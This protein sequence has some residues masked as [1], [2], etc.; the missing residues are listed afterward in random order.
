MPA[1]RVL[2]PLEIAPVAFAAEGEVREL[3]GRTMG[4]SWSVKLV[5]ETG[6]S[7]QPLQ[8]GIQRCLDRVD[9]QMSTWKAD[10]DLSRFNHAPAGSW[11]ALPADCFRV[12][13]YALQVA[14]Q[15]DGAYDPTAGALVD[16]W[17]FGPAR[18]YGD[19]GFGLPDASQLAEARACTGW[20]RIELDPAALRARQPGGVRVDLSAVAKGF[21]VDQVARWLNARDVTSH[22]IEVGGELRGTGVR[23]GGQPWWVALEAPL[24]HRSGA[25]P[26]TQTLLALHGLSVATSG[27]YRRGFGRD[28]EHFCHTIDPRS[29]RPIA[30]GLASVSVV[31]RDCMAAD[32]QSTALTVMGLER[33]LEHARRHRL[34]A[35]F[36][37][38]T[39][40]GFEEHLSNELAAML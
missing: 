1:R 16:A 26:A 19:A 38:R 17:G 33:G 3:S 8:E 7:L 20:Q 12:L 32:A 28:G 27:D 13:E 11:Q 36:V 5:A 9:A 25:E 2:V 18:H 30:H 39:A 29:G 24:P 10:S 21:A 31:H 4:T 34:A 37:Q 14:R 15:S 35:L 22:L 23:P 6:A 40:E